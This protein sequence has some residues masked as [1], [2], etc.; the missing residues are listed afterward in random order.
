MVHQ[1]K[2]I[3]ILLS[4]LILAISLSF[5]TDIRSA[6]QFSG[7][8]E[9]LD[10]PTVTELSEALNE[11]ESGKLVFK[12]GELEL[13]FMK[14]LDKRIAEPKYPWEDEK[15]KEVMKNRWQ[16]LPSVFKKS[17]DLTDSSKL[18]LIGA[19]IEKTAEYEQ[20]DKKSR[21]HSLRESL[22]VTCATAQY[23]N[24]IL[25]REKVDSISIFLG[26]NWFWSLLWPFCC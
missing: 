25:E 23:R 5:V 4:F 26:L 16:A 10:K 20:I 9:L 14:Q 3:S 1:K 21:A 18:V 12:K 17:M 15:W 24:E 22:A 8:K 13:K 7:L 6:T 11:W 2:F 19:F